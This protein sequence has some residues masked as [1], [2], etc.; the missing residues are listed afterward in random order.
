MKV[1]SKIPFRAKL[2]VLVLLPFIVLGVFTFDKIKTERG[3]IEEMKTTRL[4][5]NQI[6][7]MS[8]LTHEFQKERDFAINF[9]LNPQF[10]NQKQVERQVKQTDSI[11]NGFRDYLVYEIQDTSQLLFFDELK[12]VR[13]NLTGFSLGPNEVQLY[14]DKVIE[15]FLDMVAG[16][17]S[18]INTPLTK[19][20]MKAYL[21]LV[22]TKES[23]GK[24]RNSVNEALIFGMFQRLG[25]GKFSG[26]KGAF[27]YNLNAFVKYSPEELKNRFSMDLEGGTML[28][29]L[30][31][32]DYCFETK[33]NRLTDFNASDWWFSATGTINVLHELELFVIS[34]VKNSLASQEQELQSE[35]DSLFL[36][37]SGVLAIVLLFVSI[38]AKSIT[39]ELKKIENAAQRLKEGDTNVNVE[40][41]TNDEIGKLAATFNRMAINS[42]QLAEAARKIGEGD[43]D[44]SIEERSNEDVLGKALIQ[45]KDSLRVTT[46]ELNRKFDELEQAYKYKTDFLANMSHELRTPLNSMLILSNLLAENRDGNLSGEEVQSAQVI[47]KSGSNLL[48]LINDILDLSKIEAG[49]LEVETSEVDLLSILDHM[50]NLFKPVS[51]ENKLN[52]SLIHKGKIPKF[53]IS[54]ELRLGQILKNLLSNS[55]KFTPSKGSVNLI[56]ETTEDKIKFI[57][58]DTGIG[59]A[60]EK[61]ET[62]FGAFNQADGSTSRN[63]GGTGLG[64]SITANLV[65]LLNGVISIESEEGK[66]SKFFVEFPIG[67]TVNTSLVELPK[68]ENDLKLES[69]IHPDHKHEEQRK[70]N[71]KLPEVNEEKSEVQFNDQQIEKFSGKR[72]LL[73]DED[74]SNVFDLGG[75][76]SPL[77]IE[78]LEAGSFEEYETKLSSGIDIILFNQ[79]SIP[80]EDKLKIVEAINKDKLESVV[81][82][83]EGEIQSINDL[84]LIVKKM[85]ELPNL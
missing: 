63:Y 31:M 18:E 8:S 13:A 64:L 58:S 5:M 40:V 53:I 16:I 55:M 10:D 41:S 79:D 83:S 11:I 59:I 26:H 14:Y 23:L 2:L 61:Q 73:I 70:Q 37:L 34:R 82:N 47:H 71:K 69:K 50:Y 42:N 51:T 29:T 66:G 72:I 60:K 76:L 22:Q 25:Y 46:S 39:S 49:K 9:L 1:L 3:H 57:I 6:E 68:Y 7:K 32:I 85:S 45:M 28:N 62:I 78:L 54:D 24:I 56:I 35:I 20:E 15:K 17:G 21:S 38:I 77:N 4:K 84:D 80:E 44:V 65:G 12:E 19:E 30:R 33:T 43:Y 74:I 36:M 81:I 67:K 27:E 52:F 75:K 48:E